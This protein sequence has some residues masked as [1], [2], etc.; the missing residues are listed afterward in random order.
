MAEATTG[1][2][3]GRGEAR[4]GPTPAGRQTTFL[5]MPTQVGIHAFGRPDLGSGH[6]KLA[7]ACLIHRIAGI[8]R[9]VSR[10]VVIVTYELGA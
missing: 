1:S 7:L 6:T 10:K 8:R 3:G 5:V 4:A 9:R 2:H